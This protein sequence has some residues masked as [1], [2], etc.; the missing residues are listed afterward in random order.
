MVQVML[1]EMLNVSIPFLPE[2]FLLNM[3]TSVANPKFRYLIVHIVTAARMLYAQMW[4]QD[5]IPSKVNLILKIYE[6][7][8]M[9]VLT[10]RLRE[11][12][13]KRRIESWQPFYDWV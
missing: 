8:E 2:L 9:D 4:K 6:L 5:D 7:I 12:N 13:V 3:V 11:G 10:E 1:Q